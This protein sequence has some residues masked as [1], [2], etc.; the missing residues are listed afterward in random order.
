MKWAI[1]STSSS[2]WWPAS[3]NFLTQRLPDGGAGLGWKVLHLLKVRGQWKIASE[4]YTVY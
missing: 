1:L 2:P 3:L 4:F